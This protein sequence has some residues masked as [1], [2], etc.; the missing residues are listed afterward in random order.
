MT[1]PF[2]GQFSA[3]SKVFN[4]ASPGDWPLVLNFQT[5]SYASATATYA[6]ADVWESDVDSGSGGDLGKLVPGVGLVFDQTLDNQSYRFADAF[7]ELVNAG[8]IVV[9]DFSIDTDD[10]GSGVQ[11]TGYD[12]ANFNSGTLA[13]IRA[14]GPPSSFIRRQAGDFTYFDNLANGDHKIASLFSKD[15]IAVSVDGGAVVSAND[16]SPDAFDRIMCV[17]SNTT[18]GN[19][20]TLRSATVRDPAEGEAS[21]PARSA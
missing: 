3:M 9:F 21:L 7:V 2:F 5:G 18:S 13:V 1:Q 6:L 10:D 17:F 8:P 11:I 15:R 4:G 16:I 19:S 12:L 20:L 14:A